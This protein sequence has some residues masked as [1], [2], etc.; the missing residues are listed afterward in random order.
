MTDLPKRIRNYRD[1]KGMSANALGRVLAT[2]PDGSPEDKQNIYA[3]E[4]GAS[5]PR[6]AVLYRLA[7]IGV[8][9]TDERD[10]LIRGEAAA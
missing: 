5:R 7:D 3:W 10:A 6:P 4:R 8:I 1:E 2:G 9:T